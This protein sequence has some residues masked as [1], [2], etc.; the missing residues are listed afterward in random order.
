MYEPKISFEEYKAEMKPH[1][2]RFLASMKSPKAF[3]QDF[4]HA[5][6]NLPVESARFDPYRT[7]HYFMWYFIASIILM[8][9][10][11]AL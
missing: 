7:G 11:C 1:W 2:D 10:F 3:F 8:G 9:V 5:I 4:G 6:T